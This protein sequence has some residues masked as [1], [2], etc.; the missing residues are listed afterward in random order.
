MTKLPQIALIC[1]GNLTASSIARF[2]ML[3]E[4]LGP[5]KSTSLRLASR[6]VNS[7]RA[8]SP[9]ANYEA[10]RRARIVLISVPDPALPETVADLA[11]SPLDVTGKSIIVCSS[12]FGSE[13]L[14]ALA[15]RGARTAS[16]CTVAPFDGRLYLAEGD[17]T[18]IKQI[19]LLAGVPA[20]KV[21]SLPRPHK[22]AYLAALSCTGPLLTALLICASECLDLAGVDGPDAA[23]ILSAQADKTVRTFLNAG[24]KAYQTPAGLARQLDALRDRHPA[25]SHFL[26]SGSALA[27][28]L[29]K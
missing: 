11:R 25:L 13:E 12:L 26:E 4:C 5:V 10:L 17:R 22:D 27:A 14:Q 9:V 1:A 28:T 24:R 18:A 19:R 23:A 3:P 16:V 21:I 6:M 20:S 15:D 29:L 8:G 7:L 2:K